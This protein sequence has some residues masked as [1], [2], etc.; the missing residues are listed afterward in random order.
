M[1]GGK[2]FVRVMP[3]TVQASMK[4]IRIKARHY[5]RR[6]H[7]KFSGEYLAGGCI[8]VLGKYRRLSA[9]ITEV[10]MHGGEIFIRSSKPP[11]NLPAR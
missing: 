8:I 1:R 7:R 10:G 5:Y 6:M 4:D 11:V 9:G 3:D 2:I